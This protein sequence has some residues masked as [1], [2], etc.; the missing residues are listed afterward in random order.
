M[1]SIEGDIPGGWDNIADVHTVK[2]IGS[3]L[4][5][6][7]SSTTWMGRDKV[8]NVDIIW[9]L[10]Y[11]SKDFRLNSKGNGNLLA[12]FQKRNTTQSN[13]E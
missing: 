5:A 9:I 1:E 11:E 6:V 4:A 7:H 3:S 8:E 13:I 2:Y 10:K 12:F